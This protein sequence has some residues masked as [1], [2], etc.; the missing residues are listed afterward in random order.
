MYSIISLGKKNTLSGYMILDADNRPP[1]LDKDLYDSWKTQM[2]LYMQN[3]EHER[4]ILE[5]VEHGP[6]IWSTVEENGFPANIYSFVNHHRV[7]KDLWERVQLLMQDSCFAVLIFSPEDDPIACLN[8]A[9]AFLTALAYSRVTVQQVQGRQ[10]QNYSGTT[11]KGIATSSRGN[12]TSGQA[13]VV[14]CYNCQGEGRMARKCTQPKRPRNA[15]WFKEKAMLVEAQEAG[16][17]LDDEQLTFFADPGILADQAQTIIPHNAA[18]QTGDLDTYDSDCDDLSTAQA[19]LMANISNY[20]SDVLSEV[21]NFKTYLNDMDNQS[22]HTLQD[23]EQSPV[24]NFTDN[25]IFIFKNESK[26]KENKYMENEIDL[27][28][29]NKELNNIIC[30]VGQ[31]AQTVYRNIDLEEESR[32]KM[33]KKVKDPEVIANKISHKPIDYEKLNSPT[34]DFGKRFSPQQELSAEQAFW[35]HTLNPTIEPFY[36][37]PVILDVPSEL[38]KVSLVN[39]SLKKLK[40]HLTQFDSV[41]KKMTTPN[42]LV[43]DYFEIN[44]LKAQLQDKDTNICKLKD[45]LKSLRKNTKEENMNHDKCELE[46][47]NEEL[48]NSMAKLLSENERLCNEINHVKRIFKD[49]FDS[50]KQTRVHHKEHSD[51]LIN[52]LNLTSVENKDLKAQIQDKVFVITSLKNHLRKLKGKEIVE[53]TAHIPCATTISPGMFKLDLVS[54][55]P[56][57]FLGTVRFE[58][59]QITRIMGYGDYQL[60]NVIIS[61]RQRLRV[62]YGTD[63]Y[64]SSTLDLG[65]FDAKANI[66]IFIGYAPAEKAFKIYNKRTQIIS[67]TI[68][69]MFDELTTMASEQFSSG[70]RLHFM[71]PATSSTGLVSKLV[72]R[73]PCIPPNRDDWDRLFQPMFDEYFSPLTIAVSPVQEATA[74]RAEVLDDSPV[75]ISINKDAPSTN[76]VSL[77]KLKLIYKVKTDE[78]GGVLKNKAR[79]VAQ[80]FRQEEGSD[81]EESFAPP[82]DLT[83]AMLSAY[84]PGIRLSLPKSTYKRRNRSF[85]TL[86]EPLTWVSGTRRIPICHLQLMSMPI[87]RGV[88]T[89]DVV[90][91]EALNYGFQFNKVPMYCDN[92]SAIALF[93][94]KVQHSGAKHIDVRYHFIK[95]QVE[96]GIVELYFVWTEYQ[97]ADIFIKPLPRERFNFLINKL[98]ILCDCLD[99]YNW[100]IV[101]VGRDFDALPSE[102]DTVSFLRELGH[103]GE[104]NSLNDVV[105]DQMHQPWRT[106]AALSNQGFV[107]PNIARKFK[108]VFLSTKDSIIIRKPPVETKS[109]RKEEVDVAC[110]KGI[111]LT[112]SSVISE[113]TC[114]KPGVP[115]VTKDES[116][117][118]E[119]ESWGNDEDDNNDEN[120]SENEGNNEENKSDDDKTPFD[121]EKG[122]DSEQDSD[123][124]E[125]DSESDL[126]EDEEEVKDDD[127]EEDEF[128]HTP[129]N[130]DEEEDANQESKNDDKIKG[131]EDKGM[132]DTTNQFNDDVDARLNEPTQTNEEVVQDKEAD[133]TKVR[134]ASFSHSSDLASKFLNFLDIHPN[135]A[136]IVSRL[137]VHV[138]HKVPRTHTSTFLTVPV[139][140]IPESSPVCTTIP[141]SSQTFTSP[142]LLT[143]PT[144]PPTIEITN[145]PSTIADFASVF[146]LKKRV[147]SLENDVVEL[148]KDPLHTQQVKNRLP[149][150]LL[151]EVSNFA[152]PVIEKMIEESLNQVNLAKASYQPQ[153]TYEAAATLTEFELKKILI[154]KMN[155]SESYLTAP[156]HRECYDGLIKSYHLD[157]DFFSSYDVY[158][159]KKKSASRRD[160]FTKP[161]RPQEPTDPDWN[162]GTLTNYVEL[163]YDFKECYKALSE[164]L[165]R[166]NPKGVSARRNFNH[167]YTTS[168]TKTKAAHYDLPGIAHMVP[169]I[170][171]P[172][173]VAL[174]RYAKWGTSHCR[175]QHKTFYAYAQGLESTHDVYSTKRIMAVTRVDV[176]KKHGYVY[177]REIENWLTNL[178]GD[179]VA[180]FSIALKMFTRSLVIQKRVRDIQLGVEI[181]QKNINITK[182]DTIRPDVWKRHPYTQYQDPQGF[183]YVDSL[184]RNRLMRSDELYKFSDGTLTRLLTSFE[185][186]TKNIHMR[187]LPKRKWSFLE[188]KRSHFII[189]EINKLLKERRMMRSLE[190]FVGGRLYDSD[191]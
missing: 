19:V 101:K 15:S 147:I 184:E 36:T 60:G 48:E 189:K 161:L 93:C 185:D 51:S 21:P 62:G 13:R 154:D 100:P 8:K 35:F 58:N 145:T 16:Q 57:K 116:T 96:N 133:E 163:E 90:H 74:P 79:L 89:L 52:K 2:E 157:K 66:G 107:P 14:K 183:I 118:S 190:K 108:K 138:H 120:D 117:K 131:D 165:D 3:R 12:T 159:L 102:E 140:V 180:D 174:D 139:S 47:I 137:D 54:L 45:T 104:I 32:S 28:K 111:E 85:D 170:W 178:S 128:A 75:S 134:D 123:G 73:Q 94:N 38:P 25:E 130:T 67:E 68:Q 81:F 187:Y 88:R 164:K 11:Y 158:S 136:K 172:V 40:F 7:A 160:W 17:I 4:M 78:S 124:S 173:K 82:V 44:D 191:P 179:D 129:P 105:V 63:D 42:A 186:I 110:G 188:T 46:P 1:M 176:M 64:L 149:Q 148:K 55:P 97:L 169:N 80:V 106:F 151:E 114:N 112:K 50:I 153:S 98:E 20:G 122:S 71:T 9:M 181:Y 29:K 65:K 37:P 53:N 33:S 72:S 99:F 56:S 162:V 155:T 84:V 70:P 34:N 76:N 86:T 126:Q 18:F 167:D 43:E 103:T 95:E 22:V 23:F 156:E 26:E 141:Q 27:E 109:K 39:A 92:K 152:L 132:D 135:D 177:L 49:Q 166:E 31:S 150:I 69:V 119:S 171:T 61:R 175:A 10:G 6:L 91:Q 87:T 168:L 182:P 83:L 113:G 24:V 146:R 5:S 125:S 127:E 143:T 41:V 115:D 121:S 59:D 77:I 30:K 142:L 144:P